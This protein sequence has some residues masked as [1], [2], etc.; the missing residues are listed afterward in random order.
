MTGTVYAPSAD[1]RL[2]GNASGDVIGGSY[3]ARSFDI[4]GNG[5]FEVK[6][7]KDRPR[8]PDVRLVE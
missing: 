2:T 8:L 4:G 1:V 6:Q 3:I 7:A 5:G